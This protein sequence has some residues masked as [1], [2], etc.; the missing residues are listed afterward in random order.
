M[1][2]YLT[3]SVDATNQEGS[4]DIIPYLSGFYKSPGKWVSLK[5]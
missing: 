2:L 1:D 3:E 4:T 5:P